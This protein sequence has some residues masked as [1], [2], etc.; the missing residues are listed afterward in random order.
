MGLN[1]TTAGASCDI[2]HCPCRSAVMPAGGND[3]QG[4]KVLDSKPLLFP[5]DFPPIA[6]RRVQ[7]LQVN[8]GYRCNQ[9]CAHCHVD[10]GPKRREEMSDETLRDVLRYLE[11]GGAGVVDITGGAP[12]LNAVFR[13]L[14]EG[15]R[16]LGLQVM[17]RCN[18]TILE[19]PGQA[20]LADFLA[21]HSVE[22][23]ASLPCYLEENVDG[24]RGSGVFEAS[25]RG[26]RALNAR[27]YADPGSGLMLN[28]VYNP[29]G[30]ALP[31]AQTLLEADY[32]RALES[33]YGVRFNR[34][35]TL[36]NM[37]IRRF[38][39]WLQSTGQFDGYLSLLKDSHQAANLDA[40]MCR[41]LIS[42]DW[43]GF[44]YDCD[45]NQMLDLPIGGP[46]EQRLHIR[47]LTAP[48]QLAG[49]AIQVGEHCY[50]CTA[51]Q[52]SSCGGALS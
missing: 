4:A 43:Q 22:I 8:L 9:S 34:L 44:V 52:G 48:D 38:G 25:I 41:D 39:S 2:N 5:T 23:I 7:T 17:D 42:I 12:E 28:L 26:L 29:I 20:D 47:D 24:Q 35:M 10:A 1:V 13:P 21:A 14:V 45:F 33:R 6:R 19:E 30:A 3:R 49:R 11:H 27:G 46:Q 51:G 36:A 50:G 37:P 40:V 15:A 18:L 32:K 31:P 16:S